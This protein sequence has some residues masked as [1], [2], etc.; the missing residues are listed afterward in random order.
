MDGH[1]SVSFSQAPLS[2]CIQC[3]QMAVL[4]HVQSNIT[5]RLNVV[6]QLNLYSPVCGFA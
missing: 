5:L 4:S 2:C 6:E 3:S 1:A